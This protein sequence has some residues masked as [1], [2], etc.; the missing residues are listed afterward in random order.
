MFDAV[1]KVLGVGEERGEWVKRVVG[2]NSWAVFASV[3]WGAVMWLFRWHPEELQP[4]L[5]SSMR[6][7]YDN[8]ERWD[9]WRNFLWYNQ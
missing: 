4:S 8:A 6:Y 1:L 7:L 2:R 9:G 5:R 3:S